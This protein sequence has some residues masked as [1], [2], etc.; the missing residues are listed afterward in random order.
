M[1]NLILH[2]NRKVVTFYR[3]E[4]TSLTFFKPYSG[5]WENHLIVIHEDAYGD[6]GGSIM[7]ISAIKERYGINDETINNILNKLKNANNKN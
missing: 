5:S 3:D 4:E 1:D 6:F 2:D 7:H